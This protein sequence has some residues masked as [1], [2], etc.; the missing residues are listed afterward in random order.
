M[1]SGSRGSRSQ[2][3][4]PHR[5]QDAVGADGEQAGQ[6]DGIS[7]AQRIASGKIARVHG[8]R[9]SQLDG[10]GRRPELCPGRIG[11]AKLHWL[12]ASG[13]RCCGQDGAHFGVCQSAG[14]SSVGTRPTT[15][16]PARCQPHR[17]AV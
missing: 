2:A 5:E 6:V 1:N 16:R 3:L 11:A 13:S 15:A 7:A 14:H 10:T 8:N 9:V 4:V 12:Q 17:Q